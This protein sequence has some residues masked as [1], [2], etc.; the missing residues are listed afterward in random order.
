MANPRN[1]NSLKSRTSLN[2]VNKLP[3]F[4][5]MADGLRIIFYQVGF[6]G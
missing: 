2:S 4:V 6:C 1:N 5:S 3:K